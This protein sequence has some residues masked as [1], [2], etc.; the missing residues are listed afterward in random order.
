MRTYSSNTKR[1]RTGRSTR[2]SCCGP[3]KTRKT[4]KK[5]R[6]FRLTGGFLA[7]TAGPLFLR[8]DDFE[9]RSGS[10]RFL[11]CRETL[12]QGFHNVDDLRAFRLRWS[13]ELLALH[14]RVDQ[15]Q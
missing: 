6:I 14:F 4:C 3:A 1:R 11:D 2:K 9:P 5:E 13:H 8:L 7:L 10:G 12:L 15:R